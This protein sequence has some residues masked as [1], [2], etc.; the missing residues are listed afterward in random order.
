MCVLEAMKTNEQRMTIKEK[1]RGEGRR[2]GVS[3]R[4]SKEIHVVAVGSSIQVYSNRGQPH[5]G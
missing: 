4:L 3:H 1:L 5:G 2:L